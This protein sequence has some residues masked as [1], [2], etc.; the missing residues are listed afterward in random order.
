MFPEVDPVLGPEMRSTGEVLGIAESFGLAYF[1]SQEAAGGSLPLHGTVFISIPDHEKQAM[2]ETARKFAELGFRIK[3]TVGTQQFMQSHGIPCERSFKISE[4]QR[5]DVSD[6]IKSR[7]IDLIIN[8][9]KGKAGSVDD[10]YIRKAAIKYKVPY[11]T[12][13][14]AARAA[15]LGIAAARSGKAVVQSLQE[16]HSQ[17]K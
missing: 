4:P 13:T 15:V 2:L 10:G 3:S 9:P 17:I 14:A 1:R 5:P 7:A 16:Y 11:I 8:A 12:T 6:E